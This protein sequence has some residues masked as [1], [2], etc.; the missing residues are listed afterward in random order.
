MCASFSVQR[1]TAAGGRGECS[2]RSVDTTTRCES[3]GRDERADDVL[4]VHRVY[5]TPAAWDAEERI[6]V[7][8]GT[9]RWCASCRATYPHQLPGAAEPE[10]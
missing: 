1:H 7:E 4:A 8:A 2:V 9:E 10:L 3:C 6:D 5:L